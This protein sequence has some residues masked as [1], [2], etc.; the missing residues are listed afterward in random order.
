MTV[1][2]KVTRKTY[3]GTG[4]QFDF[5]IPFEFKS[6]ELGVIAVILIQSDGT[7]VVQTVNV[8]YT[9]NDPNTPTLVQMVV[10]PAADESLRIER[11]S[12]FLQN[13]DLNNG[14]SNQCNGA[15]P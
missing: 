6:G 5:A 10:A 4:A 14:V 2:S 11:R 1:A 12:T 13:T 8:G 9:L 15:S 7:E 3:P